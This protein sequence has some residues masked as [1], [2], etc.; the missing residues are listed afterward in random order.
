MVATTTNS[1]IIDTYCLLDNILV[2]YLYLITSEILT[3]Y[4]YIVTVVNLD[5][6]YYNIHTI[7]PSNSVT[8]KHTSAIEKY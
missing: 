2:I 7:L 3:I 5:T 1:Y 4:Y 8:V 6:I